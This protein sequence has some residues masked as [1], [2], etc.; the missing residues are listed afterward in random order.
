MKLKKEI[1]TC[2]KN[3]FIIEV[4]VFFEKIPTIIQLLFNKLWKQIF[5]FPKMI[6]VN[7]ISSFSFELILFIL[8]ILNDKWDKKFIS[9]IF[10]LGKEVLK[11]L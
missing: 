7:D 8:D 6:W 5:W 9:S 1:E 11:W 10:F 2:D 4:F 3:N